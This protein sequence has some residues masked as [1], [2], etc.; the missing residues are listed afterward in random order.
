MKWNF[1][2]RDQNFGDNTLELDATTDL[3]VEVQYRQLIPKL[4]IIVTPETSGF[5]PIGSGEK[6]QNGPHI[7][8]A[9]PLN[10]YKFDRWEGEGIENHKNPTTVIE[11][12]VDSSIK[13]IF[14][15]IDVEYPISSSSAIS[16]LEDWIETTWFG[17][18]FW[19]SSLGNWMYHESL[20]WT[21]FY[22]QAQSINQYNTGFG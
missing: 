5:I 4:S 14:K 1:W 21:Y 10:G 9:Q 16:S 12:N 19:N 7:I 2:H 17:Y 3:E 8:M 20:G 22:K 13:A 18:Y 15:K 11:F 6:N